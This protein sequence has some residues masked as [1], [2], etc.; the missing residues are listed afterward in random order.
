M[1]SFAGNQVK[2]LVFAELV[3]EVQVMKHLVQYIHSILVLRLSL[4]CTEVKCSRGFMLT[5][6][7][8]SKN[9]NRRF[10]PPPPT[11]T[12][13]LKVSNSVFVRNPQ[14]VSRHI[15]GWNLL[16]IFLLLVFYIVFCGIFDGNVG[17]YESDPIRDRCFYIFRVFLVVNGLRLC[18][19]GFE[20]R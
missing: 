6:D 5:T 9:G 18:R 1:H 16:N 19:F 3:L 20:N 4:N 10:G 15:H 13:M 14:L 7:T 12:I 8:T 17:M 11:N 2:T